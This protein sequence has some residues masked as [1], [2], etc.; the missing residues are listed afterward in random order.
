MFLEKVFNQ[1]TDND[2]WILNDLEDCQLKLESLMDA[3]FMPDRDFIDYIQVKKDR[4][5]EDHLVRSKGAEGD[6]AEAKR[7]PSLRKESD[8]DQDL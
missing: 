7:Q 3:H 1:K 6:Q 8:G 4:G 2:P 5:F